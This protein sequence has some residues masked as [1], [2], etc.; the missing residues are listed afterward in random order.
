MSISKNDILEA[1]GKMN[2]LEIVDLIKLME[3]K[4]NVSASMSFSEKPLAVSKIDNDSVAEKTEF[5]VFMTSFGDNK[6]SVIKAIRGITTL[7]LKEA[8]TLTESVPVSVKDNVS[9]KEAEDLKKILEE[10]GASVEIK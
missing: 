9:K 5:S 1:I 7:G 2:V 6:V 4:F 8:K 10:A 3:E